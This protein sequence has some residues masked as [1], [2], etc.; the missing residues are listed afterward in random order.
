[1]RLLKL[2]LISI[3]VLFGI[4]TAIASL[5]PSHVRISRAIDIDAGAGKV[6]AKVSSIKAWD[7]WNEYIRFYHNKQWKENALVTDEITITINEKSDTL[8]TAGW[9]QATGNH[10]GSGYRIIP[11]DSLHSTLQWYFDFHLHWY[12]WEKFQSI[13]YDEELGPVME[14]SLQNLKRQVEQTL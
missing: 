1:M 8:V 13:V 5:L 14:K 7:S 6:Y 12:P 2:A 11:Q 9:Q 3:V 4:L 10:F